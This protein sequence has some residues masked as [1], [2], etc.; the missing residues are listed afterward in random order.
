MRERGR[1]CGN[2]ISDIAREQTTAMYSPA[3]MLSTVALVCS[4]VTPMIKHT[5][6]VAREQTT[7]G[8]DMY[9]CVI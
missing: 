9:E 5:S 6:D 3:E 2:A 1:C 7:E 8:I 4:K